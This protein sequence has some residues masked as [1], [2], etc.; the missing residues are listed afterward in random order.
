MKDPASTAPPERTAPLTDALVGTLHDEADA[1]DELNALLRQQLEALH[2]NAPDCLEDL[3]MQTQECTATLD[4]L[5]QKRTRQKRLLGRVLEVEGKAPSL[6]TLSAVLQQRADGEEGE[7]LAQARTTVA[8]RARQARQRGETLNFAL[9]YAAELNRD[10][11]LAM[12]GAI[13]GKDGHTYT[14]RGHAQRAA[15]ERSLVNAVG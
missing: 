13:T 4:A 6:A 12:Q 5:R 7:R 15:A 14:A 11:L 10:L 3:A 1:L 2:D 8:G 9:Q